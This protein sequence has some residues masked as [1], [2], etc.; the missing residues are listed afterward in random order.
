L[1][2][3]AD[4]PDFAPFHNPFERRLLGFGWQLTFLT[5]AGRP[6]MGLYQHNP[7][8]SELRLGVSVA[9]HVALLPGR[10]GDGRSRKDNGSAVCGVAR[11]Q[12]GRGDVD[13]DRGLKSSVT[14]SSVMTDPV[15]YFG[16][17]FFVGALIGLL[18]VLHDRRRAAGLGRV[19]QSHA[20]VRQLEQELAV[21]LD[22]RSK[23][24]CEIAVIK[25]DAELTWAAERVESALLRERINDVVHE[26]VRITQ[27]LENPALSIEPMYVYA[28]LVIGRGRRTQTPANSSASGEVVPPIGA[29][30]LA[31]RIHA[32]RTM[33]S[34]AA[35]N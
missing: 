17:G 35:A 2:S 16:I 27:A 26:V 23:L 6:A 32:L 18:T 34:R 3:A 28:D 22:E 33:A 5:L 15:V 24:Q 31:D 8:G 4:T 1:R 19:D 11:F 29:G 14:K 9:K 21:A 25:R 12:V 13:P 20:D 7:S 30:A 10:N